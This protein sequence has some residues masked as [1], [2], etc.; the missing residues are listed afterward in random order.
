MSGFARLHWQDKDQSDTNELDA[1][2]AFQSAGQAWADWIGSMHS[3][4]QDAAFDAL[5]DLGLG[6]LI[7]ALSTADDVDPAGD[8]D[9]QWA[10][11]DRLLAAAQLAHELLI[12]KDARFAPV[13]AVYSQACRSG[14]SESDRQRMAQDLLD[15]A[16]M[17]QW[18]LK[19]GKSYVAMDVDC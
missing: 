17:A 15:V 9:L 7:V 3:D 13:F 5:N 1:A 16:A 14:Q 2:P 6:P 8:A 4:E 18:A 19:S 11:P 10:T 12:T